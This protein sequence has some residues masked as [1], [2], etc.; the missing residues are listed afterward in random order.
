[1]RGRDE[2][3]KEVST[4]A[5]DLIR[6]QNRVDFWNVLTM[7]ETGKLLQTIKEMNFYNLV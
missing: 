2:N 7:Y 3:R 4:P 6:Q 5:A 1:M